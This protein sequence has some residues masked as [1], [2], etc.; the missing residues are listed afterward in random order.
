MSRV[1][2]RVVFALAFIA[3]GFISSTVAVYN[4]FFSGDLL[5]GV[6]RGGFAVLWFTIAGYLTFGAWK[7]ARNPG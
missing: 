3:L 6:L 5:D 7:R 2:K 1:W 4:I